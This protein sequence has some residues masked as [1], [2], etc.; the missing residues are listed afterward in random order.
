[1][2]A[3]LR[4]IWQEAF[5]DSD[6]ALDNF[7]ATGFSPDR[8]H[9]I[10]HG[11]TPVSALYWFDCR[12]DGKKLAYIYA[13]A[14]LK[15]HRGQG[16][17]QRLMAETHE[18]LQAQ[19]Y[20]GAILVPGEKDLF[21]FYEK[22]GYRVAIKAEEFSAVATASPVFMSEIHPAEYAA[23]RREYLPE[24]GVVQEQETLSYLATYAKFYKGEDFLLAA[25]KTGESLLV[26]EIL[27]NTDACGNILC[28]LA[29]KTGRFRMPGN[30]RDFAMLLP[31]QEDC[32]VPAYF[33]LALD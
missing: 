14:T 19:G 11:D 3:E 2:I 26:H 10:C 1:M 4:R 23:W 21:A 18:I 20:A 7:S 6:E 16:L 28:A 30:D 9:Y 32:P 13:V 31:L 33:G 5:G 12:L 25:T 8:C 22:S 15:S 17:A 24:G 29:C 27:G